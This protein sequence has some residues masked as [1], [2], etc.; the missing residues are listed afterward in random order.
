MICL[1]GL[2]VFGLKYKQKKPF[3]VKELS[4]SKNIIILGEQFFMNY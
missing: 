3:E 4:A 2:G 1:G